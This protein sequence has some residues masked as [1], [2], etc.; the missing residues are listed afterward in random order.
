[1]VVEPG[2]RRSGHE[3]IIISFFVMEVAI[4]YIYLH[5]LSFVL[6]FNMNCSVF[7]H[8]RK[9]SAVKWFLNVPFNLKKSLLGKAPRAVLDYYM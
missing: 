7:W 2:S 1:M 5:I 8:S 6:N 3:D 4:L 9:T